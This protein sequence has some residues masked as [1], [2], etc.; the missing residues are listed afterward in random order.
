MTNKTLTIN[1]KAKFS[2]KDEY[3]KYLDISSVYDFRERS[4]IQKYINNFKTELI[5]IY[6]PYFYP[7]TKY[8]V[9]S[10][11]NIYNN[12]FLNQNN[13]DIIFKLTE[14]LLMNKYYIIFQQFF[15]SELINYWN[16]FFYAFEENNKNNKEYISF[17]DKNKTCIEKLIN[18]LSNNSLKDNALKDYCLSV[19][20][21]ITKISLFVKFNVNYQ[22]E[23]KSEKA[24]QIKSKKST[25]KEKFKNKY[26]NQLGK[27]EKI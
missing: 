7:F 10:Q 9:V 20:K 23:I 3:L 19:V 12:F 24:S 5:S 17:L 16:I 4:S 2:V 27:I 21:R 22:K 26:K 8:E 14:T 11:N 15:L 6:N 18:I 1:K 13:F 25:M